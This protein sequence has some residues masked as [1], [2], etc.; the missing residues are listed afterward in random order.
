MEVS[1]GAGPVSAR[2]ASSIDIVV[3]VYNAP[4]HVLACVESVLRH[5]T[6]NYELV[7]I[8]DG[9]TDPGVASLFEAIAKRRL[10]QVTLLANTRNLGFTATANRGMAR[11]DHDVVLLNSDAVVT[12]GWFDALVRCAASDARI[13]TITPFSNNAEICSFPKQCVSQAWPAGEDPEPL[14][15][16]IAAAA[17]PCYPE[18]PTGVG[19]CMYVRRELLDA[20]GPFDEA[21]G[22]GY[23]EENDFCMRARAAGFRNVLCDDAFVLHAGGKSFAGAK[24]HLGVRNTALLL[25]RHPNYL[26]LVRDF[27]ARDPIAPLREAALTAYDRSRAKQSAILHVLHGGGGTEVYV[28]SLIAAGRGHLR[29]VVA[30]VR[31]DRWRIEENRTDGTTLTCEFARRPEEAH[32]AYLRMLAANFGVGVVHAHN[33]SGDPH[34]LASALLDSR[35]PFG[36]TIH[37]L[38]MACPA[39]TLQRADGTYCGGETDAANCQACLREHGAPVAQDVI[40]WRRRHGEL[41]ARAAFVI[42]PSRWAADMLRR[43]YPD[44]RVD[45]VPHGL[46]TREGEPRSV[47]QVVLMPRDTRETVAVLGAIGPDKGARRIERLAQL[48]RIRRAPVRFVVVG[49]LDCTSQPWQ[50]D[51]ATLTIAGRYDPR[52]LAALLDHYGASFV[53]FP[54][55]GPETFSYTLSEAWHAGRPALVPPLGALAERVDDSGAGWILDQREWR[56]EERLLDRIV[57]LCSPR[58]RTMV[59]EAGA[60]AAAMPLPSLTTMVERTFAMYQE[61][62]RGTPAD[63]PTVDRLRVVEAF[64]YRPWRSPQPPPMEPAAAR[65]ATRESLDRPIAR[66]ALRFRYSVAGRVFARFLP[67]SAR[68]ALWSRLNSGR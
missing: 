37:D 39:I 8:D 60:R 54:S 29:Q 19:F 3:P 5:T 57:A 50:D 10:P 33:L 21:F 24:E 28:R 20:I 15:R 36:F 35:I 17:V 59:D 46:P 23:G 38:Q 56:D 67:S 13:G 14:R 55:L 1:G 53:L 44:V 31:G 45:V 41:L 12:S 43:Y 27:I 18:L 34:G 48:A 26:E 22:A 65:V 4:A 49:Y 64:G 52:D 16:A 25:E 51:D 40:Q 42:A 2:S 68:S 6:G 11:S 66:M 63:L 30:F 9:S 7:L 32:G 47:R 61:A 62:D 58:N